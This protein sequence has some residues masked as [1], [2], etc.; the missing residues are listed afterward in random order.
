MQ[1]FASSM[2]GLNG[3]A[4][5]REESHQMFSG[6]AIAITEDAYQAISDQVVTS[7]ARGCEGGPCG[8]EYD[9]LV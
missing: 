1:V 4:G 2:N 7:K 5:C 9:P 6:C 3:R 8:H